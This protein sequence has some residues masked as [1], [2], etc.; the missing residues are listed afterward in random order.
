MISQIGANDKP[1][2]I[3]ICN[4]DVFATDAATAANFPVPTIKGFQLY[5]GTGVNE[6]AGP[7]H[8]DLTSGCTDYQFPATERP[9]SV[10]FYTADGNA[11]LLG[12]KISFAS[13]TAFSGGPV[14]VTG[15]FKA[16]K[17]YLATDAQQ[18]FG[19]DSTFDDVTLQ[20][21][22]GKV[23]SYDVAEFARL[24]NVISTSID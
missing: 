12:L 22:E 1:E 14:D 15:Q 24:K 20:F 19:F 7:A 11:P 18:F 17:T 9:S 4:G 8:G 2:K 6:V 16:E 23:A 13:G 5:Y 21:T 3:K 10:A